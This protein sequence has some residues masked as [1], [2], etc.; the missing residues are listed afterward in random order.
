MAGIFAFQPYIAL[1]SW[2]ESYMAIICRATSNEELVRVAAP[3]RETI[4]HTA[5][6]NWLLFWIAWGA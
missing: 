4:S 6:Y 3:V 1:T 5:V 2:L